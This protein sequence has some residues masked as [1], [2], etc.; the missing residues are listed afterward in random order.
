MSE[1][2]R[3]RDGAVIDPEQVLTLERDTSGDWWAYLWH[4]R[5]EYFEWDLVE[6][7]DEALDRAAVA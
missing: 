2:R 4:E 5:G 1:V 6:P 7:L 3:L